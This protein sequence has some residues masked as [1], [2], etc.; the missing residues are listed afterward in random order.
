MRPLGLGINALAR[1]LAVPANRVGGIVNGNRAISARWTNSSH[2]SRRRSD[3]ALRSRERLVTRH[4]WASPRSQARLLPA[5][6]GR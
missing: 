5:F 6:Q 3:S 2:A 4:A 1:A